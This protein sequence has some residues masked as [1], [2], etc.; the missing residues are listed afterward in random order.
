ML[1]NGQD[2][3]LKERKIEMRACISLK[4]HLKFVV[5]GNVSREEGRLAGFGDSVQQNL[6]LH[7][8][9]QFLLDCVRLGRVETA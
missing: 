4:D 7:V 8:G 2:C 1:R 3:F 5:R 9:S 6:L